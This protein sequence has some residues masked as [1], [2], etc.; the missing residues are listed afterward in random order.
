MTLPALAAGRPRLQHGARSYHRYLLQTPSLP[1]AADQWDRQ[2]DRLTDG[3]PTVTYT[4]LRILCAQ[5]Q[6]LLLNSLL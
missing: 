3:R 1:A 5:R 2:T 4:L 6:R